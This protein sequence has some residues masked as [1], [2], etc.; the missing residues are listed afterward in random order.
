MKSDN[1]Q[2][3]VEFNN[4]AKE[5]FYLL[6]KDFDD[7]TIKLDRKNS[8][9]HYRLL[10]DQYILTLKQ[11]LEFLARELMEKNQHS[12][13]MPELEQTLS[14]QVKEYIH[15]FVSKGRY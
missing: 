11:K 12:R 5:T 10:K 1:E 15:L 2:I 8:E 13:Q 14:F 6:L 7:A 4:R 3:C 9:Y